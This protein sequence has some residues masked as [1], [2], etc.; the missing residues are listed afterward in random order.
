MYWRNPSGETADGLISRGFQVTM[1]EMLKRP[2]A[3]MGASVRW[4]LA[5]RLQEGGVKIYTSSQVREV[6]GNRVIIRTPEGDMSLEAGSLITAVGF[7]SDP[8]MEEKVKQTG[9]PYCVI[10]AGR[11]PRRIREAIQEGYWAAAEW[12]ERLLCSGLPAQG[13]GVKVLRLKLKN[14]VIGQSE[15]PE[16]W[17]E[18]LC[19]AK[20]RRPAS[21]SPDSQSRR[22]S[23]GFLVRR[24]TV[25][26]RAIP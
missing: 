25:R 1:V 3:D 17:V 13:S 23:T 4:V 24:T 26:L 5:A 11:Q 9:I 10:G 19:D 18:E 15:V 22:Q 21:G 12:V 2:F 7:E 20:G 16:T 8:A 6:K 14:G